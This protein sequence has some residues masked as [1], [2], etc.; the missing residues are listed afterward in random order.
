[1]SANDMPTTFTH[2]IIERTYGD[3]RRR[4]FSHECRLFQEDTDAPHYGICL[5]L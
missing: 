3:F 4:L 1:M 2:Q 5:W